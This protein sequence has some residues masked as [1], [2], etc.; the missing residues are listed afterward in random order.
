MNFQTGSAPQLEQKNLSIIEDQMKYEALAYR[1]C[2]QYS[3]YF[4]DQQAKNISD[5]LAQIH[6]KHYKNLLNYLNSHQ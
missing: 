4:N 5:Q 6:K 1:K 2:Q 3:N